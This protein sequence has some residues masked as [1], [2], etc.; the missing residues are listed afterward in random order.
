M[1]YSPCPS[2]KNCQVFTIQG[3]VPL[4]KKVFYAGNFCDAGE[5]SWKQCKRYNT[6][7]E[8]NLCPD[9]VLPD[10]EFTIDEILDRLENE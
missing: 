1:E 6:K 7:L 8:L 10:S 4:E 3:F 5:P 9:F 2:K